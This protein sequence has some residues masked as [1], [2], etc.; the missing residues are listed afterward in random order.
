MNGVTV[1]MNWTD[2]LFLKHLDAI[3][4]IAVSLLVLYE[5]VKWITTRRR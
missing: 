2:Y 3:L 1:V 5:G 4:Y